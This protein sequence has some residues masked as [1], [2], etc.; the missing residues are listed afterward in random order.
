[1]LA[2][3]FPASHGAEHSC[4]PGGTASSCVYPANQGAHQVVFAVAGAVILSLLVLIVW[5]QFVAD[6]W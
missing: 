2:R 1:M 6:R 4:P 5:R 3:V